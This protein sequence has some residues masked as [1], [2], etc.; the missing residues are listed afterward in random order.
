MTIN[1]AAVEASNL[2][3]IAE[4]V[5]GGALRFSSPEA[6]PTGAPCFFVRYRV[7]V[8]AAGLHRLV[9]R[10]PA[11]GTH[12]SSR[13][14]YAF[15]DGPAR[16]LLRRQRVTPTPEGAAP[17]HAQDPVTLTAGPHTLEFRFAPEHRMRAMNRVGEAFVGHRIQ[18]DAVRLEPATPAPAPGT[19][20]GRS[21]LRA[22]DTVVLFGDSITEEQFYARH[23]ARLLAAAFPEA[24][25][26]LYN[27]G[28][29][30]NRTREGLARLD[31]DV[32]ALKP[33]WAVLAFGVNDAVHM[34]P[35]EFAGN[36]R[37]LIERLAEARVRVL[38]ATPSGM[39][40]HPWSDGTW[41]HTPDRAGAYDRTMEFEARSILD[42]A[43]ERKLPVADVLGA[44]TRAGLDR[45]ALMA[46]QWHPND[47]GGRVYALALARGFG[48][49]REDITRSGDTRDLA[50]W[51]ALEK[52][53]AAAYPAAALEA[54]PA[55]TAPAARLVAA[56]F[57]RNVLCA[58]A[59]DGTPV[60]RVPT[61]HHPMGIAYSAK[62]RELYVTCEGSGTIEVITLPGFERKP[63]IALG[64]VYPV[65]IVLSADETTAWTANFFGSSLS[66]V[67]LASRTVRRAIPLGGLALAVT[68]L[69]DGSLAALV[70]GKLARVDPVSG[71]VT[72]RTPVSDYAGA[73]YRDAEGELWAVDTLK[74]TMKPIEGDGVGPEKPAP[75]ASRALVAAPGS[76]EV[77]ASDWQR[78]RLVKAGPAGTNS[79]AEV[80]FALGIL[81]LPAQAADPGRKTP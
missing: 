42:L 48:L 3:R 57:T 79:V 77:L 61:G 12:A 56:S 74:W 36:T 30:L 10:S 75:F 41:F 71:T 22:H 53:P 24:R 27:A 80:E 66:E 47:E 1:L 67:D 7:E 65:S 32:L 35:E 19:P 13:A 17:D 70:Q 63:P 58:F 6:A 43:G 76:S 55:R 40:P 34:A 21:L 49:R 28:V 2:P 25:L 38:C 60:A 81:A 8:P 5:A 16:P 14:A 18:M 39:S 52:A 73:F 54:L 31:T 78:G 64:D 51:D 9:V 50:A 4:C 46:N 59:E 44:F 62:R 26:T 68:R 37:A 15:D 72:S 29:S 69:A 20:C 11:F 33:A 45:H 23:L